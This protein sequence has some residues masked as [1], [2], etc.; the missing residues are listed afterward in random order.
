MEES[1]FRNHCRSTFFIKYIY[2]PKM[3]KWEQGAPR[4]ECRSFLLP[5][6]RCLNQ[7]IPRYVSFHLDPSN[8]RVSAAKITI[9]EN[10]SDENC[11]YSLLQFKMEALTEETQVLHCH[12]CCCCCGGM[13]TADADQLILSIKLG[14]DSVY[15]QSKGTIR[16]FIFENPSKGNSKGI[17]TELKFAPNGDSSLE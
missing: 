4:K 12:C 15:C 5:A 17:G 13:L 2:T 9:N 3:Q 6:L 7:L 8:V 14:S 16:I 10:G 1:S 11:V